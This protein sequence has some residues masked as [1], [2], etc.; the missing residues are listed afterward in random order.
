MEE[1]K[2]NKKSTA[3]DESKSYWTTMPIVTKIPVYTVTA[4][5]TTTHAVKNDDVYE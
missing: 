1:L 3:T 4:M 5:T 2:W